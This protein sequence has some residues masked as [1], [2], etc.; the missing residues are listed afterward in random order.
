MRIGDE[1]QTRIGAGTHL[2]FPKE[3]TSVVPPKKTSARRP[4]LCYDVPDTMLRITSVFFL[5]SLS[6]LLVLHV[7]ALALHLYWQ[8]W[9]FDIPMHLLGGA[10]VVLGLHTLADIRLTPRRLATSLPWVLAVVL[11]VAVTWELFQY[12]T[13][14]VPKDNYGV[15][16]AG[17]ILFGLLGA[18]IGYVVGKQLHATKL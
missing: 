2:G 15:D 16:T 11:S 1:F 4:F 3:H 14:E 13:T 8:V 7:V 12:L 5:I 17:D 10:T 18:L 9:W 6:V